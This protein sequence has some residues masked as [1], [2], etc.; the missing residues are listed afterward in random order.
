MY[1]SISKRQ[2][3]EEKVIYT[4]AN[5]VESINDTACISET[6]PPD[7]N[8]TSQLYQNNYAAGQAHKNN[9]CKCYCSCTKCWHTVC[10]KFF[11][12]EDDIKI[13]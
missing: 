1:N 10:W 4:Y 8:S 12:M 2:L 7:A 11:E 6:K 3:I 13:K 9:K 5:K